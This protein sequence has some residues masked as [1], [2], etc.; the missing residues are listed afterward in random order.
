MVMKKTSAFITAVCVFSVFACGQDIRNIDSQEAFELLKKPA[1]YLIDVRTIA[2]YVY[3]GHPEM[4]YNIPLLFWV[5]R[6]LDRSPNPNF[7]DDVKSLFKPD[8]TLILICR[9]GGRSV[10]AYRLLSKAGFQNLYNIKS[11]FEGERGENGLRSV[12]GWKNSGLPY[13]YKLETKLTFKF[14]KN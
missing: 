8:D 3:V 14:P 11:G 7:L 1:T 5:E 9:S 6:E 4:A 13:T 10:A 12:N 2:E